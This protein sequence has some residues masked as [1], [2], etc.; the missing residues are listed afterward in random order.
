MW[1]R[2][3]SS[4]VI[5]MRLRPFASGWPLATIS[6]SLLTGLPHVF[7]VIHRMFSSSP[8]YVGIHDV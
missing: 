6:E 1:M 5:E 8:L 7:G 2:S 4:S 3:R